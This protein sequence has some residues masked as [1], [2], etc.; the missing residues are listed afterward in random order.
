MNISF[1]ID[2]MFPV[3]LN[4]LTLNVYLIHVK[5]VILHYAKSNQYT[6]YGNLIHFYT[7]KL[8]IYENYVYYFCDDAN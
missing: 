4:L 2:I 3:N 7:L 8:T 1:H 6:Q 5:N